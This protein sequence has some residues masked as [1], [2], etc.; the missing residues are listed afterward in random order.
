MQDY[1]N[2]QWY[3]DLQKSLKGFT[4]DYLNQV[5]DGK[6]R[7]LEGARNGGNI[8]GP[9]T[10]FSKTGIHNEEFRKQWAT[11]GGQASIQQLLQWQIDNN[12]RVCDLE[13]TDEWCNNIS[14]ALT[15]RKI[16]K[17]VAAKIRKTLKAKMESLTPEE[18]SEKYSSYAFSGKTHTKESK[19]I[20]RSKAYKRVDELGENYISKERKQ[21]M[22]EE[23]GDRIAVYLFD[24]TKKNN[25]GKINNVFLSIYEANKFYKTQISHCLHN[26]AKRFGAEKSK[27]GFQGYVCFKISKSYYKVLY[28]KLYS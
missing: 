25:K 18:R 14:I 3:L 23:N 24:E 22:R 28:K 27:D 1:N 21:K 19:E 4:E 17:S 9:L 8:S 16:P 26:R 12:F 13:R 15:G 5:T 20:M 2:E 11:L 6:I 10:Q 7:Q